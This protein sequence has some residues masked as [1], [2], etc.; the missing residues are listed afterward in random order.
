M[1]YLNCAVHQERPRLKTGWCDVNESLQR[2]QFFLYLSFLYFVFE[3]AVFLIFVLLYFV[4][5]V[6]MDSG[7]SAEK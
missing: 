4:F 6:A 3:V 1:E 5:E 2:W 7:L